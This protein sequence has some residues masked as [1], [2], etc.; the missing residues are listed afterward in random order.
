[1]KGVCFVPH[2]R[3]IIRE[4]IKYKNVVL[5]LVTLYNKVPFVSIS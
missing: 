4:D 1:M 3:H 5:L 2:M